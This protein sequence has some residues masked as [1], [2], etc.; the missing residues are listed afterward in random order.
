MS[1]WQVHDTFPHS[2]FKVFKLPQM[3]PSQYSFHC[4]LV[5][6]CLG[7]FGTHHFRFKCAHTRLYWCSDH[8]TTVR[9][10]VDRYLFSPSSCFCLRIQKVRE[11]GLYILI[12]PLLRFHG[13]PSYA[14]TKGKRKYLLSP[15]CFDFT[16]PIELGK[17]ERATKEMPGIVHDV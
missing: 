3:V 2:S 1:P 16:V 14:Q 17:R 8:C 5:D 10:D 9:C 13:R 11:I 4:K 7:N 15:P 6:H 12:V